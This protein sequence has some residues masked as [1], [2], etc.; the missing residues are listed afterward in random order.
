M[1]EQVTLRPLLWAWRMRRRPS[2]FTSESSTGFVNGF[3]RVAIG[4]VIRY[5]LTTELPE[6]TWTNVQITD[7]IDAGLLFLND[8]TA[9]VSYTCDGLCSN[10]AFTITPATFASG[11]DP[12]FDLGTVTNPDND[13]N[14]EY[15]IVEFNA[16][17]LNLASNNSGGFTRNNSYTI[18]FDGVEISSPSIGVRVAEPVITD[19]VKSVSPAAGPYYPGDTITYTLTYSNEATGVGRGTAYDVFLTDAVSGDLDLQNVSVTAPV[20]STVTDTSAMGA[21]GVV[22]ILIDQLPPAVDIFSGPTG[23]TVTVTAQLAGTASGGTLSNTANLT[24]TGLPGG[25]TTGNANGTCPNSTGS[26]T[27]GISGSLT[28][29]RN[30]TGGTPNTYADTSTI[31]I[32]V[33]PSADLSVTKTDSLAIYSP[34][35]ILT[36]T[37]TV[38][39]NGP[40]DV[41]GATFNDNIPTQIMDWT[42]TCVPDTG[43]SCTAGPSTSSTDFSDSIDLPSGASVIYTVSA[44][45]SSSAM[46]DLVNTANVTVPGGVT[47]PAPGNNT[48]T[49]TNTFVGIP[50]LTIAKTE[51]S[52]GPYMVGDVI[53]Y[54]IVVMNTGS[55]ILADVVVNDP[56]L[57]P[58][59]ETCSSLSST[60]TCI[61]SG[62]YMV[63]QADVDAGNFVNTAS[64]TDDDLCPAAG[65]GMCEDSVTVN[66]SQAPGVTIDKSSNATGTNALGD[67]ITYTYDIVNT[68]NVTLTNVTVSDAHAGLSA[69]TCTPA[70]GSSLAPGDTMQC[71]ATYTVTQA[72]VDAGQIDNTGVASGTPPTGPD[73]SDDDSL[74]EPIAQD[75]AINIAKTPATQNVISGGTA[76]FTL[77]LTNTGNITLT[78]IVVTDALC[79][80]GPTYTGGDTNSD[81]QLQATETWTYSCSVENVTADFTNTA[82]VTTTQG[83]SDSD[84]ADVTVTVLQAD[85]SLEKSVSNST[86]LVTTNIDFTLTVTNAGPDIATNVEVTDV[87]PGG[88]SYVTHSASQG[89]YTSGTGVWD[90]GTLLLNQT[91]TLTITV[92]VGISGPYT[93]YAEITAS[94]VL[95]QDSTPNNDSTNEDDDDSVTVTPMQNDPSGLTKVVSGSNQAFTTHPSVAIG[96]IVTYQVSVNVPPG[97][98]E[99]ARLVDTMQRGF[100]YMDCESITGAGLTTSAVGGFTEVCSTLTVDDAGGGTTVDIGRRVTFDFTTLTNDTGADQTLLITYRAVI[101]DSATNVSG[102][103]LTN[104][105]TWMWSGDGRLGPAQTTINIIEPDLSISKTANAS[106]VSVGSE[107]TITL[108]IQHTGQSQTNAYDAVVTDILPVELE[109]VAGTLECASGVQDATL[110]NYNSATRTVNAVW[111]AFLF[112]GGDGQVTFR[113]R[114]ASLLPSG[115][116]NVGSVAWTSLPGDVS[117]PQTLDPVNVFSTERDYDPGSPVDVYGVNDTLT[118]NV[119]G[120]SEGA[121]LPATGFAPKLIADMSNVPSENY[122]QTGGLAVEIPSLGVNIPIV[123]VPLRNGAWNVSWLGNQA[124][125]LEGSAF[126]SWSGNS[127]L[128][129]HVYLPNGLPGPFV[130]LNRLTYGERIIVHAY[131]QKFI[132]DVRT[133]SVVLPSDATLLRHEEK[134]W[135]TL[136]TCME[137]DEKTNSYKKRV[138]VRAVLVSVER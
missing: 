76:N 81:S 87:L 103:N 101:L 122:S 52:T 69:I 71:T 117:A 62:N 79:T 20:G 104:S 1:A 92:T 42:W 24:F 6:G 124:G 116:T 89:T 137:F 107:F 108:R 88:L 57:T 17:M 44:T 98:F 73:V 59:S 27:P 4:E 135:L 93:N 72:D 110:C 61:L 90:V 43:A 11:T 49:D 40:G 115:I 8:G 125:W 7:T 67:T 56:Q 91:A 18:S 3:E 78:G 121:L 113:V 64:V 133:N 132:Y 60:E 114:V 29:E 131:G 54:S 111:N 55:A 84:S 134:A 83:A 128:T 96:E 70:Q 68:G 77:T 5:R 26:C 126:P 47:D 14:A 106:L 38:T 95:D 74:S 112:G 19:L 82:S 120:T 28:G 123:G 32:T 85:L 58:N 10:S 105:A 118:L 37:I 138:V 127:V 129:S 130:N 136:V 25:V 51:T 94:D 86:P 31:D 102:V 46:G 66:F 50:A 33:T 9:S 30:G 35:D 21:G 13:V 75:P 22:R 119:F 80:T 48:S 100:A 45:I 53:T 63:T 109:Y 12:T 23:V 65:V 2:S 41:L 34:G 39:N 99:D 36:Y 15:L 16:L 97:V